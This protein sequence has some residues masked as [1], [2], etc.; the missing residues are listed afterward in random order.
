M[1]RVKRAKWPALYAAFIAMSL[2]LII[3]PSTIM[4][5]SGLTNL[6]QQELDQR[7]QE[8][9]RQQAELEAELAEQ[10]ALRDQ[11]QAELLSKIQEVDYAKVELDEVLT[12]YDELRLLV[13]EQREDLDAAELAVQT[14]NA[15]VEAAG[16]YSAQLADQRS[17]IDQRVQD[18]I[19]QSYIG[20]EAAVEGSYR[21]ARTGDIYEAARMRVLIGAAL[22]DLG[23]TADE[24][25][26]L[27]VDAELAE[28]EYTAALELLQSREAQAQQALD[29]L[30]DAVAQEE[31]LVE[32]LEFAYESLLYEQVSLQEFDEAA[33]AE[34]AAT[35]AAVS[36]VLSA[37]Q[38]I[39]NEEQRRREEEERRR[40]EEEERLR[41]L[42][43]GTAG[44]PTTN[45]VDPN[46]L[47]W[48]GG[49]QVHESIANNLQDLLEHAA[50]DGLRLTGWGY[51]SASS[52]IALRRAH[53]GT[54]QW[55]IY[56]MPSYQC[57]P[58]TARPGR[59]M[60][61]RGLAVDFVYNGRSI[62]SRNSTGYRWLAANANDYGLYNLPSEPWHWSTNGN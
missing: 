56:S 22:G 1:K 46:E 51:R 9:R 16:Q 54:S 26:A 30:L 53:C 2:S 18:L 45:N 27:A 37:Q 48:V 49:I 35:A 11:T 32:Q 12:A 38:Q 17:E 15:T 58:P 24:L 61:E 50:R 7:E 19:V 36:G 42:R 25:L 40:R 8:L 52:Q 33:A 21:L 6:S 39:E 3:A 60:H 44:Q 34:V 14:A 5:Q 23:S 62:R 57:S 29:D 41:R 20:N 10:R 59:S 28:R 4:A 13:L 31:V 43:E 47:T 55:A